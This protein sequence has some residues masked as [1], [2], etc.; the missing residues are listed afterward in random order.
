MLEQVSAESIAPYIS[1]LR[2]A[3]FTSK[4]CREKAIKKLIS[5]IAN[6]DVEGMN[7]P[8]NILDP[9]YQIKKK[10]YKETLQNHVINGVV[11][12]PD[13]AKKEL[14]DLRV[15]LELDA[16][17][18]RKIDFEVLGT[19]LETR[20]ETIKQID[21]EI[22]FT[23]LEKLVPEEIGMAIEDLRR[24]LERVKG[25][26][27]TFL[28]VGKTGA[29]K[30]STVN[31]F[32]DATVA[33]VD[34]F[35]P[36]T[37]DVHIYQKELHEV[38]VRVIDT[39]GLCDDLEEVGNDDKYV[40]LIRQKVPYPIDAVLFIT[41]LN[42]RR[43]D[44]SEK[45]GLRII[46]EA[47]GELFWKK[48]VIVFTGADEVPS[49]RFEE[50]L[51]ERTKRIRNELLALEL[52][53]DIVYSIPSEAIDNHDLE[54]VNPAGEKLINRLYHTVFESI[55]NA[56]SRDVLLRSTLHTLE[57]RGISP[58]QVTRKAS[59]AG[60]A[61][62]SALYPAATVASIAGIGAPFAS[63]GTVVG[64]TGSVTLTG[65]FAFSNPIGWIFILGA[66][67][68]STAWAYKAMD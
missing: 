9:N 45:R 42:E 38:I 12:N 60:L 29:G 51:R 67:A 24:R 22:P 37:T 52:S 50:Y 31:S 2:R 35:D 3:D 16:E 33:D 53:D 64:A 55:E 17:D 4:E 47:F 66:A 68:A 23:E 58:I 57:K 36:C 20:I 43:V 59:V 18:V 15:D 13:V 10:Q 1:P 65:V 62:I 5:Q 21:T 48:S 27:F 25:K 7:I 14:L 34:D 40:N 6:K 56:D 41:R 39:P 61:G 11:T 8:N 46:T 26:T 63:L 44:A 49:L 30:S 54:G 28:L 19:D 32:M